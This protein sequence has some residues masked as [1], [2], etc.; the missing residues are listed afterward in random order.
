MSPARWYLGAASCTC[1]VGYGWLL[2]QPT[3]ELSAG[4]GLVV[5]IC[6][7]L[8]MR[9]VRPV[10]LHAAEAR[11]ALAVVEPRRSAPEG[12]D[13]VEHRVGLRPPG[14]CRGL[15]RARVQRVA[16]ERTQ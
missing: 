15:P 3:M 4:F 12:A 10:H 1:W 11:V 5:A 9:T 14:P 7:V 2:H 8:R 13:G 16:A 6:T